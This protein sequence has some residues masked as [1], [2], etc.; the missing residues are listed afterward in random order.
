M[1]GKELSKQQ[2]NTCPPRYYQ[3]VRCPVPRGCSTLFHKTIMKNKDIRRDIIPR[4]SNE[5]LHKDACQMW[6]SMMEMHTHG[7]ADGSTHGLTNLTSTTLQRRG[8]LGELIQTKYGV[9]EV[10]N[11]KDEELV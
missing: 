3:L 11:S 4:L 5:I 10:N 8:Y 2:Q 9:K 1:M 6:K 7:Q